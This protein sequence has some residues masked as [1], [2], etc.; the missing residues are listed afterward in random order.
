MGRRLAGA[1]FARLRLTLAAIARVLRGIAG[2]PDY[3]RYASHMLARHP[4]CAMLTPGEFMTA[5][6]RDRFE[7]PGGKCC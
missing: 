5:R 3:D 2:V 4:G 1:A 7:R 6:Q